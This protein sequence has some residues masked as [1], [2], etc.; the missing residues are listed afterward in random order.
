M[1]NELFEID[2]DPMRGILTSLILQNDPARANFIKAGRGLF[3]PHGVPWYLRE[4]DKFYKT[5]DPYRLEKFEE[6]GNSA[7]AEFVRLGVKI[8]ENFVLESDF[9]RVSITIKNENAHPVYFKKEDCAFYVPFADSYDN[10]KVSQRLRC[11]THIAA[12]GENS[13]VCAERMGD[14]EYNLGAVLARG[15]AYSY[16]QEDCRESN[17]RG[18]FA[19]NVSPFHLSGGEESALEFVVFP[20]RGGEDFFAQAQKFTPYIR[21]EAAE[22]YVVFKGESREFRLIAPQKINKAQVKIGAKTLPCEV[23]NNVLTTH[24][25]GEKYGEIRVTYNVNGRGGEAYFYVSLRLEMLQEKRAK[26]IVK[27]QQCLEKNSPLYGAYLIYDNEEHRQYFSFDWTDHNACRERMVM[28]LFLAKYARRTGDKAVKK[29]LDLFTEFL[30]REC[31]DEDSG[32]SFNNIGKDA[33]TTRLYNAPWVIMYFTELYLLNGEKRWINLAIKML[34][35]YYKTGGTHF[36]PNGIRFYEIAKAVQK[37]GETQAYSEILALFD[38]HIAYIVTTGTNY[39]PHEVNFE[40]T[41][42]TPAA[43]LLLDKYLLTR[44][45][46]Y[47]REAEKHLRLLKKFHGDQ[48]DYRMNKAPIRYWDNYWFG[49]TRSSVYGDTF[50]HAAAA[51]SAHCFYVYGVVTG[52]KKWIDYGRQCFESVYCCFKPN[53]A[54]SSAYVYPERVNGEK[55]A[56]YDAFANEQDGLLYLAYKLTEEL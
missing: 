45:E 44:E 36:Y 4:N 9:L 16:S 49:K 2:F 17:D 12:F 35:A 13:Y 18:Y 26:F 46:K 20:H 50:P 41:I 34:I 31:V 47:L 14:S 15:S 7:L 6:N 40:Q 23:K 42:V 24:I 55:G 11:H 33:S 56:F 32:R 43:C 53:G 21:T 3:E 54:A 37:S 5:S 39:P 51:H 8:S 28:P 22:G 25:S 1:K 52:Q 48:P 38:E 29:S 27:N 19:L 30:L 10:S